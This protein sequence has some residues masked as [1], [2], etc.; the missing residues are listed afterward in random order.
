MFHLTLNKEGESQVST[1][2]A[3]ATTNLA[4]LL[5]LVIP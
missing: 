1:S 3:A 5:F 4:V 2:V